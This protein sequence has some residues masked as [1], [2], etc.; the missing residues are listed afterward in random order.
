M[1][2]I[3]L[4]GLSLGGINQ[5]CIFFALKMPHSRPVRSALT[6]SWDVTSM[7]ILPAHFQRK[8]QLEDMFQLIEN[9]CGHFKKKHKNVSKNV[10]RCVI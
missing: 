5:L 9:V 4:C 6:Y 8:G 7:M 10:T 1:L 2:L 3:H